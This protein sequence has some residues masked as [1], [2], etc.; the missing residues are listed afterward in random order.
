MGL[1]PEASAATRPGKV[2][3]PAAWVKKARRRSTIQAPS[4]P[5]ATASSASS[6]SAVR[7]NGSST[8]SSGEGAAPITGRSL[9]ENDSQ[10]VGAG[11]VTSARRRGQGHAPL[12]GGGPLDEAQG[13]RL[14]LEV[15]LQRAV[16]AAGEDQQTLGF[17]GGGVQLLADR[18]GHLLVATRVQEHQRGPRTKPPHSLIAVERLEPRLGGR[19]VTGEVA[20][21]ARTDAAQQDVLRRRAQGRHRRQRRFARR[22]VDRQ[23][24]AHARAPDGHRR[25]VPAHELAH[26]QH[27]VHRVRPEL[28]LRTSVA[29]RVQAERRLTVLPAEPAE[30]EVVLLRRPRAVQLHHPDRRLAFGQ[31]QREGQ[32]VAAPELGWGRG[33]VLHT[34]RDHGIRAGHGLPRLPAG[35]ASTRP[36]GWRSAA[37]TPSS[38]RASSAP[39]PTSTPRTTSARGRAP[40]ARRSLSAASTRRWSTPARPSPAPQC[41]GCWPRRGCRATSPP[42][43]SCTWP[44]RG[45]STRPASTCTA[46]TRQPMSFATRSAPG[47]ATS[48]SI[49]STRSAG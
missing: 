5:P 7:M 12:A 41:C 36:A 1:T 11:S 38:W 45:A 43:V 35:L 2:A 3:V 25:G 49:P 48:W 8:R 10:R 6:A 15:V 47:W 28:A 17:V 29:T 37:A 18:V 30:V 13:E 31:E 34:A 44:W 42:A 4:V 32:P 14:Y 16:V 26:R 24:A 33:R 9:N 23:K 40:T 21:V 27:V 39:P 19:A 22:R 20:Q 46:T